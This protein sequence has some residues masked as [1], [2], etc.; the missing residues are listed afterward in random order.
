MKPLNIF[1]EEPDPDRWLPYDRYPRKII[2][3][4]LRG[5]PK[6]GGQQMVFVNLCK[7]LDL[8]KIPYRINNYRYC[9][10]HP[11]E[12]ACIIG[13]AQVLW[14][15]KWNNPILLGAA[16]LSHPLDC[17]DLF[18]RYNIKK[19]VVPGPW[20]KKM[21][22]EDG[23]PAQKVEAWPVGTETEKWKPSTIEK[24]YDFLIYQKLLW[25]PEQKEKTHIE[26]L[27]KV[28]TEKGLS[29]QKIVYGN[30]KPNELLELASQSKAVIFVCEHETQGLAYQQLLS[31]DIPLL[32]W[33]GAE[34][35]EDP[36]Y[37]PNRV[38][39]AGVTAVPYWDSRCGEIFDTPND[40]ERTLELFWEKLKNNEYNPREYILENLTLEKCAAHYVEIYKQLL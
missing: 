37:Y 29:F 38:K 9:R 4:I 3:R 34:Y 17:V 24:K 19:V 1:Y 5:K 11:N 7:G 33:K 32:A 25:K 27:E 23:Y 16:V 30:Y 10:Q 22:I 14:D 20:I 18:E 12:I 21:F 2:R 13:K 15:K 6:L 31:M 8:L 39:F 40:F 28:L 26:P 35:W 36:Y